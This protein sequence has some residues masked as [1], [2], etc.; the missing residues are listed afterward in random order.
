MFL[1]PTHSAP[2]PC[3]Y[4]NVISNRSQALEVSSP[5]LDSESLLPKQPLKSEKSELP[6]C[7]FISGSC[8]S[9]HSIVMMTVLE[10]TP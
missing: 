4:L 8:E 3:Y 7:M 10:C 9:L 5:M 2:C 6:S 1:I